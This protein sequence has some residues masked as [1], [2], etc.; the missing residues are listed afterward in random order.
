M[1]DDP[2]RQID[3][4]FVGSIALVRCIV[5][6]DEQWLAV[7][8]DEAGAFRLPMAR[9]DQETYRTC[10]HAPLEGLLGLNHTRDY[11]I[12]GLSRSHFQAPVEWSP[13]TPPQWVIVEFFAVDLYGP[14]S[15]SIIDRL[16]GA[17][18]LTMS[19]I[20]R[21]VTGT[22]DPICDRQRTLIERTD[23]LPAAYRNT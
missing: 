18:W 7:W 17:R 13:D 12:A 3:R 8:D 15:Q 19:E 6:D 10:L 20:A 14:D 2:L 11:L 1:N 9:R 5:G 4:P 23:L 21:G 22:G 16:P